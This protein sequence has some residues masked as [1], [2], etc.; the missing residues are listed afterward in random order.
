MKRTNMKLMKTM[1]YLYGNEYLLAYEEPK[2]KNLYLFVTNE[3]VQEIRDL[4]EAGKHIDVDILNE[5]LNGCGTSCFVGN[6]WDIVDAGYDAAFT[7]GYDMDYSKCEEGNDD[8]V[9]YGRLWVFTE[10]QIWDAID[11]L[12]RDGYLMLHYYWDDDMSVSE[13]V[14]DEEVPNAMG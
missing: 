6:G 10:Y 8:K 13:Y 14:P 4:Q 3:G 11:H 1:K 7:L 2:T 5:L 12:L 9:R